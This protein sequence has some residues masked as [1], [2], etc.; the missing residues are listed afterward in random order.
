MW[1]ILREF[2]WD[3][4]W[5]KVFAVLGVIDILVAISFLSFPKLQSSLPSAYQVDNRIWYGTAIAFLITT[6]IL[7]LRGANQYKMR[8]EGK[9]NIRIV[10]NDKRYDMCREIEGDTEI[11]RAGYRVMGNQPIED[12]V[13]FPSHL[14]RINNAIDDIKIPIMS[15]PLS[16]IVKMDKVHPGNT[17]LHWVNVFKHKLGSPKIEICYDNYS[18]EPIQLS[19]GEYELSLVARG[20][21]SENSVASLFITVSAD[22]VLNI[23]IEGIDKWNL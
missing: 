5:G 4:G 8:L 6:C 12:P 17:P 23:E 11:I 19:D 7:L 15:T 14:F 21:P 10:Y 22:Y 13:I 16:A 1:N 2:V 20:T 3:K 9:H 18:Q